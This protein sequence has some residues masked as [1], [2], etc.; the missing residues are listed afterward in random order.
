MKLMEARS[1]ELLSRN[2]IEVPEGKEISQP[3]DLHDIAKDV[4]V[5]AQVPVGGRGKAGGIRFAKD[6]VEARALAAD[7]LKME[8]GGFRVR[9]VLVVEKL[10]IARELYLSITV[11]REAGMPI[12]MASA[13]GGMEIESVRDERIF[14]DHINPL[15]GLQAYQL[16]N[17]QSVLG[18]EKALGQKVAGTAAKLYDAFKKEDAELLE[19]NPLV[20]TASGALVAG[21]A[22]A[23]IDDDSLF[24][25]PEYKDTE[26]DVTPLEKEAREKGIS[27]VQLDGD[28]GVIANGAGLTMATLDA[29]ALTGGR[30]GT[31]LDLGG[32]D[33]PQKVKEA[34]R[35]LK[36]AHPKVILMNIFGGITRCD[37]VAQGVHEVVKT[38]G[39]GAPV[40]ARI[41]GW[42]EEK[43]REILKDAGMVTASTMEE[44]ARIA[45]KLAGGG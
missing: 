36:K 32:T 45:T 29:L 4:V 11:D 21:D 13:D 28:I 30:G 16:K 23:I 44:A 8:I 25:H 1:R 40:V 41:K 14:R 35:I 37:T 15:V 5:K 12:L 17:M 6:L 3:E 34:F 39:A 24:R 7:I 2:G 33:D 27:F 31:F 18:L 26:Q 20:V 38:E 9:S 42:Y 22:K 43:A 19:I 10:D